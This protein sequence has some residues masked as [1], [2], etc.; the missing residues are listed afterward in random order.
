MTDSERRA[1]NK[2]RK[3]LT[4]MLIEFYPT[5][6][7]LVDKVNEQ[8]RKQTYIKNLIRADI[9]RGEENDQVT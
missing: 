2:Y 7:E 1:K 5:E 3:K 8:P 9:K 6:K 4:R